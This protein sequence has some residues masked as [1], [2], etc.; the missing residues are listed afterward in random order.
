MPSEQRKKYK[1]QEDWYHLAMDPSVDAEKHF[2][3]RLACYKDIEE[4]RKRPLLVYFSK[5]GQGNQISLDDVSG[6]TDLISSFKEVKEV[7]ILLHS[8][9]GSAE[10][11]ERIVNILR[12]K[13]EKVHFLI[14]H[15]AYSAATMM[16]LSGNSITLH[17]SAVLG[18]I[19]PQI[20]GIPARSIKRGFEKVR[21]IL[22]EEG[23]ELLPAYIPLIEKYSLHL[24]EIC[25][26]S[27]KLSQQ[28]VTEWL[29]EYMF[30]DRVDKKED[31][32][33]AVTFFSKYDEHLTHGRPLFLKKIEKFNLAISL[34]EGEL[35][36]LLWEAYVLLDGFAERAQYLKL[37]ENCSGIAFG[38]RQTQNPPPNALSSQTIY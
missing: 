6:F 23:P 26:D 13:F 29:T 3:H 22:K 36:E 20:N 30:A 14:P 38:K 18:P 17:P 11:T 9:G 4:Y 31:I 32:E 19:D 37:Y 7:D 27:E 28:L 33:K 16:A 10:A 5:F 24:L 15:S 12:N 25:D 34:A 1:T 2:S 21:E 35:E 8:E